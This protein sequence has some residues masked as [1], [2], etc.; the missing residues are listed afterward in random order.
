MN[1]GVTECLSKFEGEVCLNYANAGGLRL[2]GG[3]WM[4]FVSGLAVKGFRLLPP[5]RR[6]GKMDV[7]KRARWEILARMHN[8]DERLHAQSMEEG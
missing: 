6:L 4:G 5:Y 3:N 2:V 8:G 1:R 7:G